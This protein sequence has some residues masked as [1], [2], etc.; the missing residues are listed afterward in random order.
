MNG[1][2]VLVGIGLLAAAGFAVQYIMKNR[3]ATSTSTYDAN[4]PGGSGYG[5]ILEQQGGQGYNPL[6]PNQPGYVVPGG[7]LLL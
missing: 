1:G 2:E 5:S 3:A 4:L 7:A 6:D